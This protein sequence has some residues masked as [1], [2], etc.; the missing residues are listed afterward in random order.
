MNKFLQNILLLASFLSFA[1]TPVFEANFNNTLTHTNLE[2]GTN[3]SLSSDRNFENNK[4]ANLGA[5]HTKLAINYGN[6]DENLSQK[7]SISFW[8]NHNSYGSNIIGSNRPLFY[9]SNGNSSYH[10]GVV[11][12]CT[13]SSNK[14][15][16]VSYEAP[17]VGFA[18]ELT[19]TMPSSNNA[20]THYVIS[21]NFTGTNRFIKVYMNGL[22]ITNKPLT[23]N[24]PIPTN[25]KMYFLGWTESNNSMIG[26]IDDIKLFNENISPAKVL[27][28]YMEGEAENEF[29]YGANAVKYNFSNNLDDA[30][31]DHDLISIGTHEFL[32]SYETPGN[33]SVNINPYSAAASHFKIPVAYS[34]NIQH[35]Y[36][37][38]AAFKL[39]TNATIGLNSTYWPVISIY[40][41]NSDSFSKRKFSI[42]IN[43]NN[44][45]IMVSNYNVE[46]D[47][48]EITTDNWSVITVVVNINSY[49]VYINGKNYGEGTFNQTLN[50][51]DLS[52]SI[53][54]GYQ[55]N[56]EGSTESFRGLI[57]A[58]VIEPR[59]YT[60][61]EVVN[62]Q[63]SI[64]REFNSTLSIVKN[65]FDKTNIMAFPNP[66]NGV[67]NFSEPS[68]VQIY[69]L[70]GRLVFNQKQTTTADLSNQTKGIYILKITANNQTATQK[71]IK[72]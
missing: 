19:H 58:V 18:N 32:D 52:R 6:I 53:E 69:D 38:T 4:A 24:M 66:T 27:D 42:G 44:K 61:N 70:Q 21:Y 33:K 30:I 35:T 3:I 49:K 8:H 60:F 17:N 51:A 64:V 37:V 57:D 11:L 63:R 29:V 15:R 62:L 23:H 48:G 43:K 56:Y 25:K 68:N 39:N 72:K 34:S 5:N 31:G 46:Q 1:Q 28:L 22:L 10:E 59:V 2:V 40:H 71:I 45:K 65:E 55:N 47:F 67:I 7:A 20:W 16:L 50:V 14:L 13:E 26:K 12:G 36:S 54:I 41:N 9:M